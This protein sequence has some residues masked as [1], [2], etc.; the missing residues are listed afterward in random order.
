M[1]I[2]ELYPV[3]EAQHMKFAYSLIIMNLPG[4]VNSTHRDIQTLFLNWK[5]F[6]SIGAKIVP[7]LTNA[8]YKGNY[9]EKDKHLL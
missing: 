3:F 6:S 8:A 1:L 9:F 7:L 5:T 4:L 2:S